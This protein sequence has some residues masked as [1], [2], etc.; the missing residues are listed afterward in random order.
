M[1]VTDTEDERL[2]AASRVQL[3]CQKITDHLVKR[4]GDYLAVEGID[5]QINLIG[6][7]VEIDLAARWV[8]DFDAVTGL[9]V[10]ALR[11][12][13][14]VDL[15]RWFMVNQIAIDHRRTVAVAKDRCAKNLAGVLGGGGGETNLDGVEIIQH[16]AIFGNVLIKVAKAQLGVREFTVEQIATVAFIDDDAVILVNRRGWLVGAWVEQPFDHALDGG[17]MQRSGTVGRL[18]IQFFD[19]KDIGKALQILHA[20]IF[21]GVGG[22]FAQGR[23]INEKEDTAKTLHF[24]Q[25]IDQGDAGF[26]F[27]GA[28][29]HG[30]QQFTL[31]SG[32]G[33]FHRA[34][35]FNLIG[36]QGKPI[37]KAFAGQFLQ[38]LRFIAPE[39][40]LQPCG[41]VPPI[42][43]AA[44]VVGAPQIAKPDAALFFQLAQKRS[45]IGGKNKGQ[46]KLAPGAA[47]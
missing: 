33:G 10:D 15:K 30:H 24:E 39:Q 8:I 12:K 20:C 41:R 5:L 23:T 2:L 11:G 31:T 32:N 21:E 45:P 40:F 27:A 14:R 35:G 25:P 44:Q 4:F 37:V 47:R 22:L 34:N 13:L 46:P 19:A 3:A 9:P 1:A 38:R 18:F 36:T 17:D 6:C 7:G 26:G 43:R 16:T 42:Q 28:S 29:C